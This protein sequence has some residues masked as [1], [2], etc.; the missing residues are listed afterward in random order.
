MCNPILLPLNLS[1]LKTIKLPPT[2]TL[3][4]KCGWKGKLG[5]DSMDAWVLG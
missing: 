3:R 2:N 4:E 5:S 1:S